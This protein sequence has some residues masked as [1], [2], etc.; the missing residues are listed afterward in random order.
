MLIKIAEDTFINSDHI[1]SII[2]ALL[3]NPPAIKMLNGEVYLTTPEVVTYITETLD[4]S[5]AFTEEKPAELSLASRIALYLRDFSVGLTRDQV[6]DAFRE[7]PELI[8]SALGELIKTNTI[9]ELQPD[10]DG[11]PYLYYHASNP[12]F[13]TVEF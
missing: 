9:R 6:Y 3:T 12:I 1:V 2:P 4:A 11:D 5:T 13:G 7:P 10:K 8:L